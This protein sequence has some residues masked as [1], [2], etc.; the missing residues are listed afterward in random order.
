MVAFEDG[1]NR[2]WSFYPPSAAEIAVFVFVIDCGFCM[3]CCPSLSVAAEPVVG[4]VVLVNPKVLV[5][6]LHFRLP[7][8]Y[9]S[10][11]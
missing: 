1:L 4:V 2:C 5:C 8:G 11:T 3:L 7:F 9:P 6:L 10:H